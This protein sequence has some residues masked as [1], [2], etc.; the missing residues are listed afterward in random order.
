MNF[1][2]FPKLIFSALLVIIVASWAF[3]RYSQHKKYENISR[4][5]Y[6]PKD[7]ID[8]CYYDPSTL[9]TYLDN[10]DQLTDMAKALW[11]KDGIDV[12]NTKNA[13]GESQSKINRYNSLLRYTR[14]LEAKLSESKDLKDQG[15]GNDVIEAILDKG[16][17]IGAVENERDKMADYEFLKGKNV[18]AHSPPNEIWELQ[19][20]LNANDYNI[21]IDGVFNPSTDS[22]LLDFQH[23][24]NIY[25]SHS[26]DDIT[27]KKLA[28]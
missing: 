14:L 17:T 5:D 27:L 13:Y 25:P 3:H 26:C 12:S 28:E 20:L 6:L 16:I 11:L 8:Y 15:L 22:A 2:F 9:A 24:N 10:C 18:S 21:N 4:F 23:S 7:S 19:K 1:S